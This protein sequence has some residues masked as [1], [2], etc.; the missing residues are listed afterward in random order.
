ML[1]ELCA[2][3]PSWVFTAS[4]SEHVARC[5]SRLGL[6]SVPFKGVIDCRTCAFETKHARS[7]FE[8]AM[9]AA[10]VAA[11]D[12]GDCLLCDDAVKNIQAAKAMGWHT[13]LVGLF[14]RDTGARIVCPEADFHIASLHLLPDVLPHLFRQA[15]AT[16]ASTTS[17]ATAALQ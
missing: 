16:A 8:R 3:T 2:G 6:E 10:G 14:D 13:V 17:A 5:F 4:T 9:A 11:G 1:T 12:A 15:D 7:S